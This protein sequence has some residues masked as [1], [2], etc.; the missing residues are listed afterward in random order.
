LSLSLSLLARKYLKELSNN[1]R[2]KEKG[3]S[4]MALEL[5]STKFINASNCGPF[6]E[7]YLGE[8][9]TLFY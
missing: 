4:L 2:L 8:I 7:H 1:S 5:S 6:S 9:Q 3:P